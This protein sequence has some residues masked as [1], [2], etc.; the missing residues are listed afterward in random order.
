MTI[1]SNGVLRAVFTGVMA[2]SLALAVID[3]KADPFE[4]RVSQEDVPGTAQMKRGDVD[5]AIAYLERA[6]KHRGEYPLGA[7]ATNLCAAFVVKG[8]L[9]L[10][11]VWCDLAVEESDKGG[12]AYNNRGV[13]RALQGDY[14]AAIEDFRQ[15]T[16]LRNYPFDT[17]SIAQ[18]RAIQLNYRKNSRQVAGRNLVRAEQRWAE[19]KRRDENKQLA[20]SD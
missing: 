6:A 11:E 14:G 10:A 5:K 9:A 17:G 20:S 19:A 7:V 8:A 16:R 4:V 12:A 3:A 15:A 1:Q 18:I 13:L 2:A